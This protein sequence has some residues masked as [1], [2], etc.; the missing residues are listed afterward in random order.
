MEVSPPEGSSMS[1]LGRANGTEGGEAPHTGRGPASAD[2]QGLLSEL[3]ALSNGTSTG[4]GGRGGLGAREQSEPAGRG[5]EQLGSGS[6]GWGRGWGARAGGG[7]ASRGPSAA[8]SLS[9]H[10]CSKG[11]VSTPSKDGEW[12]WLPTTAPKPQVNRR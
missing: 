7:E 2:P 6:P 8:Q 4:T 11:G 12:G 5:S 9:L 10:P 3:Q 1:T